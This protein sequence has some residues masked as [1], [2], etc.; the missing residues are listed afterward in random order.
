MERNTL[1]AKSTIQ[2]KKSTISRLKKHGFLGDSYEKVLNRML[3][4]LEKSDS[5]W[6]DRF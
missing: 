6:S 2:L 5:Y 3:E 1:E 4:F